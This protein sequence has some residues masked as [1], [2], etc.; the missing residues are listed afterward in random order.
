M[1]KAAD[2]HQSAQCR[3]SVPCD[4]GRDNGFQRDSVQGITRMSDGVRLVHG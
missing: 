2:G 4:Q 3:P 1:T